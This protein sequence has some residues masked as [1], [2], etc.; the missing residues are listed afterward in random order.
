MLPC[1]YTFKLSLGA[2]DLHVGWPVFTWSLFYPWQ[3]RIMLCPCCKLSQSLFDRLDAQGWFFFF[4][5]TPTQ[6]LHLSSCVPGTPPFLREPFFPFLLAFVGLLL[7]TKNYSTPN[8]TVCR[9]NPGHPSTS[10]LLYRVTLTDG[11][12]LLFGFVDR[13]GLICPVWI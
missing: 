11:V 2:V 3:T 1:C 7:S 12:L 6:P 8:G 10:I 4:V 9:P 13:I 5:L